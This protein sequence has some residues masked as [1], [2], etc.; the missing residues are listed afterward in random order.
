MLTIR[1]A[2]VAVLAEDRVRR[3]HAW[4]LPHLRQHFAARLAGTSDEELRALVEEGVARARALG[5]TRTATIGSFVH[6]RIVFGPG[7]EALPWAARALADR[8]FSGD[9]RIEHLSR[10]A[11][12]A[13]R[14]PRR[15][16]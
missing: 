3:L 5:A 11:R 12:A 10:R 2:Q 14:A 16:S 7:L 1:A 6:L 13:L 15:P 4:L 8:G 9:R